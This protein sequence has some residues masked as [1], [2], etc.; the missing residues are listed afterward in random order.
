MRAAFMVTEQ[1]LPLVESHPDQPMK[2]DPA[3][4]AAVSAT[5]VLAAKLALQL[6]PQLMPAGVL[7]TVPLPLPARVTLSG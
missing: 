4:A 3:D 1:L 5:E 6:A 7:V 2:V